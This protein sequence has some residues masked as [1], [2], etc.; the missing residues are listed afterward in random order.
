MNEDMIKVL[1]DN[2]FTSSIGEVNRYWSEDMSVDSN[3]S[4]EYNV[5]L[6][7]KYDCHYVCAVTSATK[8]EQLIEILKG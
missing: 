6:W 1:N 5:K 7:F 3:I 2:G 8:L 4:F